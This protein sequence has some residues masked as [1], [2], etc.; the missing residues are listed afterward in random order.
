M[1]RGAA[2]LL[3]RIQTEGQKVLRAVEAEIHE[4]QTELDGLREKA[5]RWLAAIGGWAP[6]RRG[7]PP[8]S[9]TASKATAQRSKRGGYA[10]VTTKPKQKA[11]PPVDWEKV[12]TRLPRAFTMGDLE[13][14]TPA[15]A[16][17]RQT[18]NIALARWS[19]AGAIKKVADGKY[20]RVGKGA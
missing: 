13:K 10:K 15:L 14:A 4:R 5:S 3:D 2:P 8:I 1:A 18:R 7:R 11:S 20:R 19:R 16:E 9:G 6:K 17:H 12:L